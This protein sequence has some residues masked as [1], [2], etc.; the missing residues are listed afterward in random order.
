MCLSEYIEH[1]C[2]SVHVENRGQI[3]GVSSR[4]PYRSQALQR[5]RLSDLVLSHLSSIKILNT[6]KPV[7]KI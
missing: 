4:L 5:L 6:G 2:H 1:V 3:S 7:D